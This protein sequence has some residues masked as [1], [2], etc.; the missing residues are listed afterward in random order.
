SAYKKRTLAE[1]RSLASDELARKIVSESA[2]LERLVI[3]EALAGSSGKEIKAAYKGIFDAMQHIA[4]VSPEVK[5]LFDKDH[6][7]FQLAMNASAPA[8]SSSSDLDKFRKKLESMLPN[9][10]QLTAAMRNVAISLD[11][12][13]LG[14]IVS[15]LDPDKTLSKGFAELLASTKEVAADAELDRVP[16]KKS[17]LSRA[18]GKISKLFG[19]SE[20][21]VDMEKKFTDTLEAIVTR[22]APGVMKKDVAHKFSLDILLNTTPTTLSD[23]FNTFDTEVTQHVDNKFLQASAMAASKVSFGKGLSDIIS[24]GSSVTRGDGG[25]RSVVGAAGATGGTQEPSKPEASASDDAAAKV[26]S[27]VST[28]LSDIKNAFIK[29]SA[30]SKRNPK[31]F[32]PVVKALDSVGLLRGVNLTEAGGRFKSNVDVDAVLD[33]IKNEPVISVA[34][35]KAHGWKGVSADEIKSDRDVR[36]VV[37]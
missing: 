7:N 6:E 11:G 14:N 34:Y 13:A 27:S 35:S 5:N 10:L 4:K 18:A 20:G 31:F 2:R 9:M 29:K 21:V 3:M 37:S 1:G 16:M 25:S 19:K 17:F 24:G 26:A 33:A 36:S 22:A 23:A 28:A 12:G 30:A 15:Q 32:D 8:D